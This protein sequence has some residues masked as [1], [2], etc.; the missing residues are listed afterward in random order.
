ML[1]SAWFR[2]KS[3]IKCGISTQADTLE[4]APSPF[5]FPYTV[6]FNLF[7][8]SSLLIE[9]WNV[10]TDFTLLTLFSEA[11]VYMSLLATEKHSL[12]S[13]D[14]CTVLDCEGLG[15]NTD[16]QGVNL[17]LVCFGP[18]FIWCE[19]ALLSWLL[20]CASK[21]L[22]SHHGTFLSCLNPR[23]RHITE[24]CL[25]FRVVQWHGRQKCQ[26][27]ERKHDEESF[28][29]SGIAAGRLL[30]LIFFQLPNFN[31]WQPRN[32]CSRTYRG[33][34]HT[35]SSVGAGDNKRF[36]AWDLEADTPFSFWEDFKILWV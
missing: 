17:I 15:R 34:I 29:N 26:L 22:R 14:S 1:C 27:I 36:G 23:K 32:S 11:P 24:C 8:C 7:F 25:L 21:E 6:F 33:K 12:F 2:A 35:G 20:L 19:S 5:C 10:H 4:S 18:K 28:R 3:H 13:S 16:N 31:F 9:Y 30:P